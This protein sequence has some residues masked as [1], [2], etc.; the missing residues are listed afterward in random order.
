MGYERD[1]RIKEVAQKAFSISNEY[2]E[3]SDPYEVFITRE[4]WSRFATE[5]DITLEE[6]K[7]DKPRKIGSGGRL[8]WQHWDEL[9][10]E[11]AVRL[12]EAE[13]WPAKQESLA[14]DLHKWAKQ[15]YRESAPSVSSIQ[16]RIKKL[17]SAKRA[18]G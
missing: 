7:E 18:R 1:D 9:W 10:A 3:W 12:H 5:H 2:D 4:E 11:L 17:Y 16:E 14:Q 6:N 15:K 8:A 13:S